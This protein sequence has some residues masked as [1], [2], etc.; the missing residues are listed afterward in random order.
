MGLISYIIDVYLVA[1]ASA[2]AANTVIR[3]AVG[4]GF[5]VCIVLHPRI[6]LLTAVQVI[7]ISNV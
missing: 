1:S 7:C 6:I 2:L 4:A 3:S 5:P